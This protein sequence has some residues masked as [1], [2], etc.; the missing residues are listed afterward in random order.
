MKEVTLAQGIAGGDTSMDGW[1]H[2]HK[3]KGSFWF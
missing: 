1:R 3:N 2:G